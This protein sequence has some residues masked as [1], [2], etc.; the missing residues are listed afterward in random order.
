MLHIQNVSVRFGSE[1][2]FDNLNFHI[3]KGEIVCITGKSGSGKTT[4]LR[5]IMGF[6]PIQEGNIIVDGIKLSAR[7]ADHI[8]RKIAWMPQE[9]AIPTEW[10]S[11][12]VR[13]PFELKA[14]RRV[15]FSEKKLLE[16]FAKLYLEEDLL[17]KRVSEISGG[18][19]Q[20]V[21]LAVSALLN[22]KLI[23]VDEPTSALDNASSNSVI[24]FMND[25]LNEGRSIIAVSHDS[26]FSEG[27]T[28][29]LNL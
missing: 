10:V 20:R 19:R 1:E 14:N 26:C 22:K 12:M 28:R 2:I 8:R 24:N 16:N 13:L 4:L 29:T 23:I 6:V 18:Q 21:M 15:P 7:T 11:E 25:L 3:S 27:C 9:L 5:A 17:L